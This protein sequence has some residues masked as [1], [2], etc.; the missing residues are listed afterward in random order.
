[1]S[2]AELKKYRARQRKNRKAE[3]RKQEEKRKEEKK[4]EQKKKQ[5]GQVR[6]KIRVLSNVKLIIYIYNRSLNIA[7]DCFITTLECYLFSING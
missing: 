2:P 5:S 1:M 4:A 7:E 6:Y 3:E